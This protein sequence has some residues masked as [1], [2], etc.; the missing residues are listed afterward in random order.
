MNANGEGVPAALAIL[1]RGDGSQIWQYVFNT[2]GQ[3][4]SYH[5][6]PLD[7]GLATDLLFLQFYGTGIRG[8]SSPAAVTAQIGGVDA[9]VED[10][11]P[12]PAMVG[13]DQV[14]LRVPRSLMGRGYVTVVVTVDVKPS[15]A[16]TVNIR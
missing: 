8:R 10:A 9:P 15:N 2:E 14:N 13:L 16:V 3:A 1:A 11:G 12:A 6:V 7:L 4:G 5:P